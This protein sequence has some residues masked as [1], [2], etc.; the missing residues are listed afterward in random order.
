M[1]DE[2]QTNLDDTP[3]LPEIL[4]EP[5]SSVASD[6]TDEKAPCVTTEQPTVQDLKRVGVVVLFIGR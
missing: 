6:V 5:A 2:L 3:P 4:S 1:S